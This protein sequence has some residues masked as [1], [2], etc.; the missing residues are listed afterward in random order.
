M[1]KIFP[2]IILAIS[3]I[4]LS[5]KFAS[6]LD[7]PTISFVGI[8]QSP[9]IQGDKEKFYLT[10][11]NAK[12]VQY[13][14]FLFEEKRNLWTELTSG[15]TEVTSAQVPYEISPEKVF[16]LGKYK[17]SVWV[18][19]KGSNAEYDSSYIAYLNCVNR[20]DN[21]RV[22]LNGD[23]KID[24]EEYMLGE[25]VEINGIENISGMKA[26]YQ[27]KLHIYNATKNEWS[28]DITEYSEGKI[29][30]RP[31]E[32]GTYVIDVWA[33][34][35][36]STLWGKVNEN[37]KAKAYEGWKLKVINITKSNTTLTTFN[38]SLDKITDIQ[39]GLNGAVTDSLGKWILAKRDEIKYYVDPAN[40]LNAEG[41]YQF[42][43][44]NYTGGITVNEINSVLQGKGV[45]SEKGQAYLNSAKTYNVSPAYLMAH[46]FLET[47]NGSSVL[48]RGVIVTQVKGA[49]VPPRV[50]YNTFG[51]GAYDSDPIKLGSEYAYTKGWISVELA[52][53]GGAEWISKNYINSTAYNQN[54]LY[55]MRWNPSSTGTHQYATDIGWA[56][57][58]T[59]NIKS[60]MDKFTSTNLYFDVPKYLY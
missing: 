4:I 21:N 1:K 34:S 50:A 27:Y 41:K 23:M 17:L 3:I 12:E 11:K 38:Y 53:E 36:N 45:L 28:N 35:A 31:K 22:Y 46:S 6:A 57:K 29:L 8:S 7:K 10:T 47:G 39:Y 51:I 26:P 49:N 48:S 13:R 54:T 42:L 58:Q 59:K 44:L 37:P 24:K 2:V 30:W 55:K 56:S 32:A 14:M 25:D 18:R 15:Y 16:D 40:F 43:K 9:L 20:D 60:I 5:P 52:I 33:M 19:G